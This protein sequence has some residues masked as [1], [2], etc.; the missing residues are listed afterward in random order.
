MKQLL[1]LFALI[2]TFSANSQTTLM[3]I[4]KSDGTTQDYP[5]TTVDSVTYVTTGSQQQS[6]AEIVSNNPNFSILKAAVIKAG[7]VSA[8]STGTLT[9]FAPDNDAFAASGISEATINSLPVSAIDSILKYH[10]IGSVVPSSAVPATVTAVSTLLNINLYAVKNSSTVLVNNISVKSADIS[11][12][13][14]VIHVISKVLMPATI[15]D[16]V[17]LD[18]NFSILKAAVV[19]AGL[20]DAVATGS[21]TVFA[22]DND[23]FAESGIDEAAVN[24][25]PIEDLTN[26][27]LYHVVGAKVPSSAVPASDTVNTL[28]TTNLYAS[29]NVNGVF[30]NGIAVK[31]ADVQAANGVIHVVSEVL[32]PPTKTIAELVAADPELSLLLAAVVK[33][34][35]AGAVSGPGKF[36]AF[37]P[38]NAA[39]LAA[40]LNETV[41]QFAPADVA[42]S[43]ALAHLFGTNV[44]A[45]DLIQDA[46]APTLRAGTSLVVGLTPPSVKIVGSAN[47]ASNIILT[48]VNIIA[49]NGVIHKIDRVLQ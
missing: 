12:S 11:A 37:A 16:I 15:K 30:M 23:A 49:T 48:G 47:P 28:L 21:L 41:I 22:P 38:I 6:I 27:L 45:S 13:N 34:G 35:L 17:V 18:P 29:K 44:F 3:R 46:Q 10:V 36:T 19:R 7:L 33:A 20:A 26:I 42:A 5:I 25:L 43:V 8:L 32:I 14:G 2:I 9:V 4:H 24:S 39:F 1:L 31:A 40:G